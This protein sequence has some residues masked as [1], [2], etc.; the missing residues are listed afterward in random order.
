VFDLKDVLFKATKVPPERQK[1]LG[2]SKGK[3]PAD[4][5]RLYVHLHSRTW[6]HSP[7]PAISRDAMNLVDGRK[8]I[9]VGTPQG[10]EFKDPSGSLFALSSLEDF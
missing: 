3:L 7:S 2:L 4:E 8:F 5:T 1:I 10:D 6:A 9:L